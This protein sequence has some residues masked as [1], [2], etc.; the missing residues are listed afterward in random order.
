[1]IKDF[2]E[3]LLLLGL[4]ASLYLIFGVLLAG[5]SCYRHGDLGPYPEMGFLDLLWIPAFLG[6]C[7]MLKGRKE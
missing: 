1:M 2:A 7:W 4:T 6:A 3:A 5:F